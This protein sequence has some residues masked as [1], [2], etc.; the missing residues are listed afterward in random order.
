MRK[1]VS[2]MLTCAFYWVTDELISAFARADKKLNNPVF[3]SYQ[4]HA[5]RAFVPLYIMAK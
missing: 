3:Y 2:L 5:G 4:R 1:K